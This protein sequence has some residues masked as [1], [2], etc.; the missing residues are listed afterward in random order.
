MAP[1]QAS[2]LTEVTPS[3]MVEVGPKKFLAKMGLARG[4]LAEAPGQIYW[5]DLAGTQTHE[6]SGT[7]TTSS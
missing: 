3:T 2:D 6:G 7:T 4:K 5:M 1:F